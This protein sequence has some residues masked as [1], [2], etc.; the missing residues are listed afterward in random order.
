[1]K[2]KTLSVLGLG[3]AVLL[4]GAVSLGAHDRDRSDRVRG[5]AHD[6]RDGYRLERADEF[7]QFR[8]ERQVRSE[9]RRNERRI[10]RLER[11]LR[12]LSRRDHFHGRGSFRS[13]RGEARR[14]EF[15]I[16]RLQE[17]NH[18]LRGLLHR[19]W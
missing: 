14:L 9:I 13:D 5:Y 17:R 18:Y 19:R 10:S 6:D 1:M 4:A 2:H 8:S 12:R 7:R 3:A 16:R 11:E 15:E